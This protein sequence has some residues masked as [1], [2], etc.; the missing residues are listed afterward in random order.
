MVNGK[1]LAPVISIVCNFTKPTASKP[2]LL[3]F[4][5]V[6]TFFHEFGHALARAAYPM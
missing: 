4:D 6:E 2:S 5:E 3:T 1:R